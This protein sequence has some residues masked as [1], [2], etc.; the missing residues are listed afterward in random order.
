VVEGPTDPIQDTME[1]KGS[2][3]QIL[4]HFDEAFISVLDKRAALVN[5]LLVMTHVLIGQKVATFVDHEIPSQ[6]I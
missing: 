5:V 1:S 2:N 4:P 6:L 3:E